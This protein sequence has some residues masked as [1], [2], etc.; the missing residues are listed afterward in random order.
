VCEP[1]HVAWVGTGKAHC[2]RCCQ[3]F[4]TPGNF[5][6]HRVKGFCT[7]PLDVGLKLNQRQVWI[8]EGEVDYDRIFRRG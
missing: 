1:Q 2:A 8:T 7:D 3:T 4:S 6:K 5:D